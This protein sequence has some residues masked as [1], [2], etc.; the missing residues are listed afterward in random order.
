MVLSELMTQPRTSIGNRKLAT[1][2][3]AALI[4]TAIFSVA[5]CGGPDLGHQATVQEVKQSKEAAA[6]SVDNRT[7]LS[8]EQK[9]GL[10]S[11]YGGAAKGGPPK[12]GTPQGGK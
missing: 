9:A 5:G 7:D 8:P 10:K 2:V 12:G 6:Q 11:Y 3:L 1:S 4:A